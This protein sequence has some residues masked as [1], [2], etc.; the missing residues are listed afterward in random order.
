MKEGIVISLWDEVLVAPEARACAS[1]EE[2]RAPPVDLRC[3]QEL[4]FIPA[5][6]KV[7]NNGVLIAAGVLF[8]V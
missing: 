1:D 2:W 8:G 7:K 6:E 5:W 4:N 3:V